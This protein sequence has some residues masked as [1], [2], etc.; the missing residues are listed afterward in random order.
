MLQPKRLK[1]RKFHRGRMSGVAHAGST[2]ATGDYALQAQEPC[3]MTARQI[4]AAYR[5]SLTKGEA[6]F[7]EKKPIPTLD[8][9]CHDRVEPFAKSQFE[10]ASPKTWA[11]YRFGLNTIRAYDAIAT[12]KLDEITAEHVVGFVSHLQAKEWKIASV[13]SALRAIRRVFRLAMRWGVI[14][15]APDVSLLRGENHREHVVTTEE[16]P[17]I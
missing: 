12:R 4:E 5:T 6:G 11:W 2:I 17:S 1:H 16:E 10:K 13:N 8:Q 9:F 14:P 15:S 3:W 7:R